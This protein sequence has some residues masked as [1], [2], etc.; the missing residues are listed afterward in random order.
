MGAGIAEVCARAGC[1]VIV[2][3]STDALAARAVERI[4]SSFGKAVEAGKLTAEDAA[5]ARGSLQVGSDLARLS[6]RQLVIE[7]IVESKPAKTELFAALDRIVTDPT[8][9][10]ASNTSSIPIVDLA[11]A[12]ARPG[13]VIGLHF[14]NPVPVMNLVELVTSL[15]TSSETVSRAE[16]FVAETLGKKVIHAQDRAGFIVNALLIPFL[17]DAVRMIEGGF[18]TPADIDTGMVEGCRHP[19]GPLALADFVGLDTV[20]AIAE[21]LHEEYREPRYAPPP[22]LKRMVAAGRLGRKSGEGFYSYTGGEAPR[23]GKPRRPPEEKN[24]P[25]PL[26]TLRSS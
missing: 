22:L 19:M 4:E 18:A 26:A 5:S 20:L 11:G 25:T 14:F 7:A 16:R 3:E 15:Q 12:T 8:A 6:D 1:D 23:A 17:V 21:V 10:L 13:A 9:I 2:V 24:P